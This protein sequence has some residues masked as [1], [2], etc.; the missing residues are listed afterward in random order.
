MSYPPDVSKFVPFNF[1]VASLKLSSAGSEL[2]THNKTR[3]RRLQYRPSNA[4]QTPAR[5][6]KPHSRVVQPRV[7][8]PAVRNRVPRAEMDRES[9]PLYIGPVG[10]TAVDCAPV[11]KAHP[12]FW[13]QAAHD[14]P[15]LRGRARLTQRFDLAC[16]RPDERLPRIREINSANAFILR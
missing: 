13:E 11:V 5:V 4:L 2:Q 15:R 14:L 1:D 12:A 8:R 16:A 6:D 7:E 10:L 9:A 3:Q